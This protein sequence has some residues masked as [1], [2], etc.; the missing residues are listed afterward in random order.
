MCHGDTQNKEDIIIASAWKN[1]SVPNLNGSIKVF[2]SVA[3]KLRINLFHIHTSIIS[4][5][6]VLLLQVSD[7]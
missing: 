5:L 6:F 4:V 7:E 3:I 2:W 1:I